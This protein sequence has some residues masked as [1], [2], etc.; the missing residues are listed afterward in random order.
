MAEISTTSRATQKT[1]AG[2]IIAIAE[3]VLVQ[4]ADMERI[5]PS[6]KP[7]PEP[8]PPKNPGG[9][10]VEYD[11]EGM[12]MEMGRILF[13]GG[14]P[15]TQADLEEKIRDWFNAGRQKC[16][17]VTELKRHAAAFFHMI[18]N[19]AK[20]APTKAERDRKSETVLADQIGSGYRLFERYLRRS[21]PLADCSERHECRLLKTLT[22]RFYPP[23]WSG[24][25]TASPAVP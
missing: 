7:A 6:T 20:A 18:K 15:K 24:S 12:A 8:A 17:G 22:V 1:K 9:R 14:L 23:G 13:V 2:T 10:K 16:P 5:W 21:A 19:E 3:G 25:G 11:W 4:R